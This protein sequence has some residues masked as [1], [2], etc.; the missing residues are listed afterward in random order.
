MKQDKRDGGSE[1]QGYLDSGLVEIPG[2]KNI[3]QWINV[4]LE[5]S[6]VLFNILI[7][8]LDEI[9]DMLCKSQM[10]QSWRNC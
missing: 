8:D 6:P 9:G 7:D 1:Q 5:G 4:N 2:P 3:D 10:T